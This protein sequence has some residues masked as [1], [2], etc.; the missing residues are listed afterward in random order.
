MA[1]TVNIPPVRNFIQ[2]V[3]GDDWASIAAR[4]LPGTPAEE[5]VGMLQSWN[6]YVAFRPG[7]G[8]V[9]PSDVIF[10][11]PPRAA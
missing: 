10:V 3:P 4:E 9:T 2:P 7:G 8:A 6:L 1:K 11:E 5:A